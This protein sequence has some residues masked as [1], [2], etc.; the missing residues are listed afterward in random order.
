M[1]QQ[2]FEQPLIED[3]QA[4]VTS[5]RRDKLRRPLTQPRIA[6]LLVSLPH[7][8]VNLSDQIV[9]C[10]VITRILDQKL[11]ALSS[12]AFERNV[13]AGLSTSNADQQREIKAE[14]SNTPNDRIHGASPAC[15]ERRCLNQAG[16]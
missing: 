6:V 1:N 11:R 5:D 9:D 16:M 3:A 4:N 10:T 15:Y 8:T 2:L 12:A 7:Q 14:I 13:C